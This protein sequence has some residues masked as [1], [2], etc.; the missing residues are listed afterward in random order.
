MAPP[1]LHPAL[2]GG[3]FA[4][5]LSALPFVNLANCCC[6]WMIAGG[7]LAA[8]IMQLNHPSPITV[9]DGAA[10][11]FLAGIFGAIVMLVV[12]IPIRAFVL[13]LLP[14]MGTWRTRRSEMPPEVREALRNVGP[15]VIALAG[16]VIF[17]AIELIFSTLGGLFGALVFRKASPPSEP[18]PA[19]AQTQDQDQH[20]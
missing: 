8:Y 4:G 6:L 2:L 14:E 9:G 7:V 17:I 16:G 15:Q 13:P 19:P 5:V 18:A 10:V 12:D 1:K 3:L 11:G 20:R